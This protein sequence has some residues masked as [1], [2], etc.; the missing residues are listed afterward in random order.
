M[1]WTREIELTSTDKYKTIKNG[2]NL[3][4][5]KKTNL[6]ALLTVRSH[7]WLPTKFPEFESLFP[8]CFY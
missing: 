2:K 4:E 1:E 5:A 7:I 8:D 6:L 3:V